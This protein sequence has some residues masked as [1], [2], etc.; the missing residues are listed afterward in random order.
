VLLI[1]VGSAY[2][3]HIISHYYDEL[4]TV[5][6]S[7][8][9]REIVFQTLRT[10]GKPVLL[11][12]LTTIAGFGS[13]AVSSV[14]PMRHFGIF[15]A[16][17][18]LIALIVALTFIPALLLLRRRGFERLASRSRKKQ[19]GS[20]FVMILKLYHF[21]VAK[22]SLGVLLSL[23]IILPVSV[24]G[25]SK[26]VIDNSMIEYFRKGVEVR[27][28][29]E[30]LRANF[31][32]TKDFS[33]IV[34]GRE[35]GDLTNPEVLKAMD[36]LS[37]YLTE[38][39]SAVGK[40]I[41]FTDYIK[42][43]NKVMNYRSTRAEVAMGSPDEAGMVEGSFF[44]D[45]F[46]AEEG[47]SEVHGQNEGK[48]DPWGMK[49]ASAPEGNPG[50]SAIHQDRFTYGEIA[51]LMNDVYLDARN[52][53]LPADEYISLFMRTLNIE[54]EAYNEI[55]YD[56]AKYPVSGR[57]ELQNLITQ[58]LLLFSGNLDDFA[59]DALEPSQARMHVQLTTTG[60]HFTKVIRRD[61]LRYAQE[62]FPE[63]YEVEIAGHA[64]IEAA[65]TDLI[66]RSQIMSIFIALGIVFIIITLSFRSAK[67]GLF[68]IIPLSI[69][70]MIIFG[71]MGFAGFMLDIVTS[72]VAS[73]AIGIG[74]D[75]SIHFLSR[76]YHER[77][78][79]DDLNKVTK[80]ALFSTGKAIIINAV[81][82]GAGFAVLMFSN[83]TPIATAGLL[84]A[85]T[86]ITTSLAAMTVLPVLLNKLKPKFLS[87]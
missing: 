32:G 42:R 80:K 23:A 83:F 56:P 45:E 74:I 5:S 52:M 7:E 58:Y 4:R 61:I 72:L 25:M 17:G 30:F 71:F 27:D 28:A 34:R 11:A 82:V 55:P 38:E 60:N 64:D 26:I 81:T 53:K 3:I 16:L 8:E 48:D 69:A 1:A 31:G 10:V 84:V 65:F 13:L 46:M 67:A 43:M 73:V 75:Y 87:K 85:L 22:R 86:M 47:I 78:A 77:Q 36:D 41:G 2:G 6:S 33:I 39:Y 19:A 18:V 21:I 50:F 29:D 49:T 79:T 57:E 68:G 54:G 70:I 12:G 20:V 63:G 9:N 15:N 35:R 62:H 14:L 51:A 59:D 40:V 76:Y 66:V 44:T 24:Y 37:V